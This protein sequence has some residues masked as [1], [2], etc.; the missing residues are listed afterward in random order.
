MT[1]KEKKK[2]INRVP[3]PKKRA[4]QAE[5]KNLRNRTFKAAVRTAT[6]KIEEAT[7]EKGDT[8][9]LLSSLYSLMDKGVKKGILTIN[10][11]R[12]TKSR[13]ASRLVKK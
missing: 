10:K 11:A 8:G 3:T 13:V 7:A 5:K 12:R 1:K 6:R 2:G 9:S 4:K